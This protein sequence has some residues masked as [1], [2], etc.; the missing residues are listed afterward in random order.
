LPFRHHDSAK[1]FKERITDYIINKVSRIQVVPSETIKDKINRIENVATSRIKV[2]RYFYCF[3]DYQKPDLNEVR[4][5]RK[6]FNH[7][8]LILTASRM[9]PSKRHI[10]VLQVLEKLRN[11]NIDV[12]LILLDSGSEERNLKKYVTEKGI[13]NFVSFLGHVPNIIDY[14]SACDILIH[15]SQND[16]SSSLIK[17]AGWLSKPVIVSCGVGDFEEYIEDSI[18]GYLFP[19][20]GAVSVIV[21]KVQ[22][23]IEN[24]RLALDIGLNLKKTIVKH[25]S[26]NDSAL[27]MY[28]ELLSC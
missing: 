5:I 10:V 25:F 27:E 17:E 24:K 28:K 18:N 11:L 22:N 21:E 14:I 3:E 8:V 7:H 2:I 9:I 13:E 26:Y 20:E 19:S 16:V 12:G 23:L 1:T 15:P 6:R 4:G